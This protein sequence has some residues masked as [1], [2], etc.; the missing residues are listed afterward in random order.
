MENL[1]QEIM[2]SSRAWAEHL[3]MVNSLLLNKSTNLDIRVK[4]QSE[5]N[6]SQEN[7]GMRVDG[8]KSTRNNRIS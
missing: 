4:H 6:D 3:I 1:L 2:Y 5:C 7:P 8:Y